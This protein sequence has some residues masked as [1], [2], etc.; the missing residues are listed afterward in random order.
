[1]GTV[2]GILFSMV[3]LIFA[4]IGWGCGKHQERIAALESKVWTLE[5]RGK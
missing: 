3:F 4:L 1:M 5:N 2:V